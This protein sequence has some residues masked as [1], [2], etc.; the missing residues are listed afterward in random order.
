MLALPIFHPPGFT[1]AVLWQPEPLQSEL[2]IGMWLPPG[3]PTIVIVLPGGG[4]A[5]GPV[6]GPWHERQPVA[7]WW[8]PVTE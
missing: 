6:F 7:P 8:T 2:P 4:P 1:F 5:N 3:H